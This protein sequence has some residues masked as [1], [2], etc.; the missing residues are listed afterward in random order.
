MLLQTDDRVAFRRASVQD[1]LRIVSLYNRSLNRSRTLR[2]W[3]WEFLE[4]PG[5][6]L[7]GWVAEVNDH[8][9][10]HWA[11]V[12]LPLYA[13]GQTVLSAKGELG[14][15]DPLFRG[16]AIFSRLLAEALEDLRGGPVQVSWC[17][18]NDAIWKLQARAGY[19]STTQIRYLLSVRK[20]GRALQG[21][22]GESKVINFAGATLSPLD[23]LSKRVIGPRQVK[24]SPGVQVV[25]LNDVDDRFDAL[26]RAARPQ[27]GV[28]LV[29]DQSFLRWRFVRN[30]RVS[31]TFLL[32]TDAGGDPLGY[33]VLAD[34]L[35]GNLKLGEI[36][37]VMVASCKSD[38]ATVL[39]QAACQYFAKKDVEAIRLFL[40]QGGQLSNALTVA[41][42]QCGFSFGVKGCRFAVQPVHAS[43]ATLTKGWYVTA[44]FTEGINY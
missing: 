29:R 23:F 36:V 34:R 3:E 7:P 16:R 33:V 32:A 44:A 17:F 10:A 22:G 8:L 27:D 6:H 4:G 21:L 25:E 30:P 43:N 37:D 31:Y 41:A 24:T 11:A 38:V 13:A 14:V 28:T 9:V 15:T 40:S 19:R 1:G 20:P 35:R 2:D 26:W 12:P 18:P 39:V 5:G 42:R